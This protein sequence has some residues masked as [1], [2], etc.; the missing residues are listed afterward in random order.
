M[1]KRRWN[2]ND[3]ELLQQVVAARA[4]DLLPLLEGIGHRQLSIEEREALRGALAYELT[5]TGLQ[6]NDE[7]NQYGREIDELIGRLMFF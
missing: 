3:A 7:P 4:P 1:E 2:S 6:E 5:A